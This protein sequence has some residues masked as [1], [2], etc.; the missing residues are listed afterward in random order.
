VNLL[1]GGHRTIECKREVYEN[2]NRKV[3]A[4]HAR[5]VWT[6]Q[7]MTN[8]YRNRHGRVFAITPWRLVEYWKMTSR[9]DAEEYELG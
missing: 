3:D 6:H 7:G 1:E 2:Y 4:M 9:F 8:W 5:M